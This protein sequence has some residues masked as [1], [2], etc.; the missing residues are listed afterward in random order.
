MPD[1]SSTA[2]SGKSTLAAAAIGDIRESQTPMDGSILLYYFA[3]FASSESLRPLT[4]VNCLILQLLTAIVP[5]QIPNRIHNALENTYLQNR[6]LKYDIFGISGHLR[7]LCGFFQRVYIVIDGLDE[8]EVDNRR[9]L[10]S[11]FK[12]VLSDDFGCLIK[13]LIASRPEIDI[14]EELDDF[15]PLALRE[16]EPHHRVDMERYIRTELEL[17]TRESKLLDRNQELFEEVVQ[18][19]LRDAQGM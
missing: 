19:L 11:V 13:L 1:F 15:H 5:D 16:K 17:K 3:D 4:V 6:H 18:M 14:S 2:G 7:D 9:Q 10:F 12:S 8:F